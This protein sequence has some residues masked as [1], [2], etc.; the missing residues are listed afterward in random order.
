MTAISP[1]RIRE[2]EARRDELAAQMKAICPPRQVSEIY[3]SWTDTSEGRWEKWDTFCNAFWTG[4]EDDMPRY[5]QTERMAAFHKTQQT[6]ARAWKTSQIGDRSAAVIAVDLLCKQGGVKMSPPCKEPLYYAVSDPDKI[7]L[8]TLISMRWKNFFDLLMLD[9]AHEYSHEGTAREQAAHR[10]TNLGIPTMYLTGS[11]MNGYASS[12]YSNLWSAGEEFRRDFARKEIGRFVALYGYIKQHI[13]MADEASS[14]EQSTTSD[15]EVASAKKIGEAPGI[16]P[17]AILK[18]LLP[19]TVTMQKSDVD[20]EADRVPPKTIQ[21]VEIEPTPLLKRNSKRLVETVLAQAKTDRWSKLNGQLMGALTEMPHYCDVAS[22]DVGNPDE[23]ERKEIAKQRSARRKAA[24]Q[25]AR[26]AGKKLPRARKGAGDEGEQDEEDAEFDYVV[27][28]PRKGPGNGTEVIRLPGINPAEILPKEQYML[29]TIE[30]EMAE[31]RRVIVLAWN[32]RLMPRLA[33]LIKARIGQP[34][35]ILWSDRVPPEIRMS[36]INEEIVGKGYPVMISNPKAIQTG[37]NNLVYFSTQIWMQDPACDP[38]TF[39]QAVGRV[40]RI[41]QKLP[42]RILIPIY[43]GTPQVQVNQLLQHKVAV[44]E[45]ADGLDAEA[46]M[47]AAGVRDP[48]VLDGLS[49]ARALTKL[50]EEDKIAN[51]RTFAGANKPPEKQLMPTETRPPMPR[52][53]P[54]APMEQPGVETGPGG[55][56]G[57]I[58]RIERPEQPRIEVRPA[59][60]K[61]PAEPPRAPAPPVVAPPS[62]K[63]L[64]I[65]DPDVIAKLATIEGQE[66]ASYQQLMDTDP[67]GVLANLDAFSVIEDMNQRGVLGISDILEGGGVIIGD[68]AYAKPHRYIVTADGTIVFDRLKTSS[69]ELLKK[70]AAI[71]VNATA[72]PR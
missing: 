50:L 26:E 49:F 65:T 16:M 68:L 4:T 13:S 14:N 46:A 69:P 22:L 40:D 9:E 48:S 44:S 63:A 54:L 71:G 56:G 28:Y 57:F 51:L 1:D 52:P 10:L 20:N 19:M 33:R 8:A 3:S 12:L 21:I 7:A 23:T 58:T 66:W 41:K 43:N 32:L 47:A 42:T 25:A 15:R 70:L 61:P 53:P 55:R 64:R 39:R 31:G 35:K 59:T 2:I 30:S 34:A 37:L 17:L 36:W 72:A 62:Q 18:Y 27:R 5:A 67:S 29:D 24:Q 60:S 11:I 38:I 6:K 45:S